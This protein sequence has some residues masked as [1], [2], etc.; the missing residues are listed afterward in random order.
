MEPFYLQYSFMQLGMHSVYQG[1]HI[2]GPMKSQ[3]ELVLSVHIRPI[4][5]INA[6][7][8]TCIPNILQSEKLMGWDAFFKNQDKKGWGHP[9]RPSDPISKAA[10]GHYIP[11]QR[12]P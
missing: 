9:T 3:C 1:L 10:L 7:I 4:V 11:T 8:H 2:I 12:L 6:N 5:L